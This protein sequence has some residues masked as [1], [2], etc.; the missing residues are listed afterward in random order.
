MTNDNEFLAEVGK[1]IDKLDDVVRSIEAG[2]LTV[3][4]LAALLGRYVAFEA[5]VGDV[6]HINRGITIATSIIRLAAQNEAG[7][8]YNKRLNVRGRIL[9]IDAETFAEIER[10]N[11]D[12]RDVL[13][14]VLAQH[15]SLTP[16]KALDHLK[17]VGL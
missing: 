17:M 12:Q 13:E 9:L 7:K 15:G 8:L 2:R 11:S 4:A 6:G 16:R 5:G 10:L 3:P 14:D 1:I